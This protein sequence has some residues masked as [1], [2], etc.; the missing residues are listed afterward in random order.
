M[1]PFWIQGTRYLNENGPSY[2]KEAGAAFFRLGFGGWRPE[3]DLRL[4]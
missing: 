1:R 3:A 4:F 2:W